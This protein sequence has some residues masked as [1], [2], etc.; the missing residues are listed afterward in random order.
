MNKNI[1]YFTGGLLLIIGII[2]ILSPKSAFESIV[3]GSGIAIIVFSAGGILY[4]FLGKDPTSSYF[5]SSSILGLIFGIILVTNAESTIKLISVLLGIW[6]FVTGLSTTLQ[7]SKLNSNLSTMSMPITRLI[8]GIICILTPF[9][10][11]KLK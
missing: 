5:L 6:L 3:L 11:I 1:T 8:L 2:F 9:I 10:F 4:S 7:M